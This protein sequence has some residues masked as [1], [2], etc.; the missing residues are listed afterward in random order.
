MG[1][2]TFGHGDGGES[3]KCET[4]GA[5][6]PDDYIGKKAKDKWNTRALAELRKY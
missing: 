1:R 5:V 6:V 4:C 3:V 2:V